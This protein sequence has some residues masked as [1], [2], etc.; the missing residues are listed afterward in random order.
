MLIPKW[1]L[2]IAAIYVVGLTI[3][4]VLLT[5]AKSPA[6]PGPRIADLHSILG[7]GP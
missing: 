4:T 7:R 1:L 2:A 6:L 3:W 5:T